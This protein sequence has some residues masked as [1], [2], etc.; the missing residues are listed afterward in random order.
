MAAGAGNVE[1][2]DVVGRSGGVV[3]G[4]ASRISTSS[5]SILLSFVKRHA[6]ADRKERY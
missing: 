3:E 6:S 2:M 1:G 4:S 5:L